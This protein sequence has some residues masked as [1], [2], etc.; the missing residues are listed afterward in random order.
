MILPIIG[1]HRDI[2]APDVNTNE[3]TMGWIMDAVSMH[4]GCFV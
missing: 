1:P 2:P 4:Q 3:V